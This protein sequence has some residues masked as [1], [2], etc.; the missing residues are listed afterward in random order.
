VKLEESSICVG[1]PGGPPSD[2][3]G[4]AAGFDLTKLRSGPV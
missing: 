3:G 2:G 1:L 4:C